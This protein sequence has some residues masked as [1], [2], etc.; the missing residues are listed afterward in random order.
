M[1]NNKTI[2]NC[3]NYVGS[4]DRMMQQMLS[5]LDSTKSSFIDLFAGAGSVSLNAS[6]LYKDIHINDGNWQLI[7]FL[8]Y[9]RDTCT[10]VVLEDIDKWIKFFDLSKTNKEGYLKAREYYNVFS[11]KDYNFNPALFYALV[12]HSFSHNITFN[13]SQEFNV[14]AGTNRSS[15]NSSLREKLIKFSNK[16]TEVHPTTTGAKFNDLLGILFAAEHKSLAEYMFYVDPPYFVADS[17]YSRIHGLK[18]TEKNERDLYNYLDMIDSYKGSFLLSNTVEDNGKV[19]SILKEWMT[20]YNVI[21]V[22]MSYK[23]CNYQRKNSGETR[24]ILVKNY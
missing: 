23:N 15:F 18:W 9:L 11:N 4:K 7:R 2:Q 17:V 3:M 24:E 5:N 1:I 20:K 16:I 22:D 21:E 8:E 13:S 19:N 6:E 12:S 10:A 14:P